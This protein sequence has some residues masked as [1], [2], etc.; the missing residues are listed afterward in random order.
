MKSHPSQRL[1][2][3]LTP[4]VVSVSIVAGTTGTGIATAQSAPPDIPPS[5]AAT[6]TMPTGQSAEDNAVEESPAQQQSS[7][8]S[9][10][11]WAPSWIVLLAA[12]AVIAAAIALATQSYIRF[13]E[14]RKKL[15]G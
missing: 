15:E 6:M 13:S 4:L 3:I 12:G 10:E 8:R 9:G 14:T 5:L 7:T 1:K 2:I 11:I